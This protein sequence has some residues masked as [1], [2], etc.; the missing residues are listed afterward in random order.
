M[1]S[2]CPLFS[3]YL[4]YPSL[5]S[6]VAKYPFLDISSFYNSPFTLHGGINHSIITFYN[7][8]LFTCLH[9]S[10]VRQSD[11][12]EKLI[13]PSIRL[14]KSWLMWVGDILD[15]CS[16]IDCRELCEWHFVEVVF[17]LVDDAEALGLG[18]SGC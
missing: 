14:S 7:V 1:F 11:F 12:R 15:G 18:L 5:A 13:L 8:H 2:P 10:P 17:Y 3:F 4:E 6:L 9:I 16:V